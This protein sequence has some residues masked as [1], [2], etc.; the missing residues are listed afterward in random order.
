VIYE[1]GDS[2]N[3]ILRPIS[4]TLAPMM[5]LTRMVVICV[6]LLGLGVLST[7]AETVD[8]KYRGFVNLSTFDCSDV[9]RSSFIKRVCFDK[10]KS[11]MLIRLKDTYYHYCNIPESAVTALMAADSMGRFFNAQVKGNYDCRVNLP[12]N[13]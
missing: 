13:Y 11:Y 4:W 3:E 7:H 6:V 9:T 12:P 10:A 1:A 8:V 2:H 5:P